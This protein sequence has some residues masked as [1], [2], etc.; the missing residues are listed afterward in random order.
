[1]MQRSAYHLLTLA[2]LL[3]PVVGTSCQPLQRPAA[4]A[5]IPAP[6]AYELWLNNNPKYPKIQASYRNGALMQQ[7]DA[8]CPIYICLS[9]QRG[10][11]YV[12]DKVAADWPVSTGTENHP[13]PTGKFRVMEKQKD[14]NS[15]TWGKIY[16]AEGQCVLRDADTRVD[17]IPEGGR[18]EGSPMPYWQR[19]T[20]GGIGMHIGL[21]SAGERL[22]HG[23]VRTPGYIAR[24]LFRITAVKDTC[25]YITDEPE[26]CYPTFAETPAEAAGGTTA[27]Y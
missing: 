20:P 9:Q 5:E 7:A 2:V 17:K 8:T 6:D 24:E 12:G 26:A 23:C 4:T 21:V 19:L 11:L 16:N 10:R 22:S 18:F 15:R 3:L 14:Y 25:V 13:T 27:G 1:M